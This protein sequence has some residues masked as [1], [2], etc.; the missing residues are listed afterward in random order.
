MSHPFT[1]DVFGDWHEMAVQ[2]TSGFKAQF[3]FMDQEA[4][5]INQKGGAIAKGKIPLIFYTRIK[6]AAGKQ[7]EHSKAF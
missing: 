1:G 7:A 2:A 3:K 6:V 5:F 4:G